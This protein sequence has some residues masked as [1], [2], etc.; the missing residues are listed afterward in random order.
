M[1]TVYSINRTVIIVTIHS[2]S[3][4]SA[5]TPSVNVSLT[6]CLTLLES[7]SHPPLNFVPVVLSHASCCTG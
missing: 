7:S 2:V 5:L 1:D 3:L 4:C 6:P